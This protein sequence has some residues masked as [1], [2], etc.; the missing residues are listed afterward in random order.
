MSESEGV[1]VGAVLIIVRLPCSGVSAGNL[2]V[3]V[4]V[5]YSHTVC[6]QRAHEHTRKGNWS[7]SGF[8]SLQGAP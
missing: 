8:G 6:I 1:S 3:L 5:L 7:E 4:R 2:Q